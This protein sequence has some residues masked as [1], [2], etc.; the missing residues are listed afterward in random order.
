MI[1][2]S[3]PGLAYS[4]TLPSGS[5]HHQI[6]R[7]TT[8]LNLPTGLKATDEAQVL[9]N[10]TCTLPSPLRFLLHLLA[11]E[12][13]IS[14]PIALA[15]PTTWPAKRHRHH[16]AA[17]QKEARKHSFCRAHHCP[18]RA[19]RQSKCRVA[20]SYSFPL[21]HTIARIDCVRGALE[22]KVDASA[23]LE[24]GDFRCKRRTRQEL[25]AD[26]PVRGRISCGEVTMV[27]QVAAA[28]L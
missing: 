14:E 20:T 27:V 21:L 10:S 26:C 28:N 15:I 18:F 2:T 24:T 1:P 22:E 16:A 6:F 9:R 25:L 11:G 23:T 4:S 7:R 19:A 17:R 5:R 12:T 3:W 8:S 13:Q